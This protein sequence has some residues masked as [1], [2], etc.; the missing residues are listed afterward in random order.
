MKITA[1]IVSYNS[2]EVIAA[3]L[4]SVCA[5]PDVAHC[6]VVDNASADATLEI[7]RSRFPKAQIIPNQCNI[8]FGRACNLGL[9]Q[10]TT[11]YALLLNPD[12]VM[13]A[14]SIEAL[15]AHAQSLLDAAIIAPVLP[16]RGG[17]FS[18][19]SLREPVIRDAVAAPME[20]R[21]G[22]V[23][24]V[25]F[26]SGAVALWRMAQMKQVGFFDSA[27]FLFYEDDDISIR[28]RRAGYQL[29]LVAGLNVEHTPGTSCI[30]TSAV[31]SL[32]LRSSAWS[33]LY[34]HRKYRGRAVAVRMALSMLARSALRA[35][36]HAI[37]DTPQLQA[38]DGEEQY[39]KSCEAELVALEK[40]DAAAL[41]A[42]DEQ[43]EAALKEL[44][45]ANRMAVQEYHARKTEWESTHKAQLATAAAEHEQALALA[46]Q[47]HDQ[48]WGE[49]LRASPVPNAAAVQAHER[50]WR[51]IQHGFEEKWMIL[52]DGFDTQW[53]Y[54]QQEYDA[55]WETL[56]Q[57]QEESRRQFQHALESKR[58]ALMRDHEA[59]R[60]M[61]IAGHERQRLGL[62]K[63]WKVLRQQKERHHA[64]RVAVARV[65]TAWSFLWHPGKDDDGR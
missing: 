15:L 23:L 52:T 51:D 39:N 30:L 6:I 55:R 12:A 58:V 26:V 47:I 61:C 31:E 37:T 38:A 65:A 8:G 16:W 62:Q 59:K 18:T 11:E 43:A 34:I 40:E 20:M 60:A 28:V 22:D 36:W 24:P 63:Q 19:S 57:Q 2:A 25:S 64:G 49:Q 46:A 56:M 27:F 29:L 14:G 48:Q 7:V 5:H 17:D 21:Q 54:A 10:V 3:A 53:R 50:Q 42:H 35:M 44:E 41:Q 32:K 4:G 9:Q 1:I 13:G 33:Y 45:I